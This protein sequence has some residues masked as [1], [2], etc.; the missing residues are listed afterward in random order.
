MI[1]KEYQSL[2][3]NSINGKIVDVLNI[4]AFYSSNKLIINL[5]IDIISDK[6]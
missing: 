5:T 1:Y 6:R 4:T 3:Q 2:D